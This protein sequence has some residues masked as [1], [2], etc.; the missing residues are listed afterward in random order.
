M[1]IINNTYRFICVHVPK[2]GG[3]SVTSA[4]SA[5]TNYCDQEIGATVFGEKIQS[6]YRDRFGLAKHSTAT[7]IRNLVGAVT[8]SRYFTFGFV[9]NPFTRALSTFHFLRKWE[10]PNNDFFER[11]RAFASFD[12]YVLS[13]IW[14]QGH[15]PDQ[16]FRPQA[17]WL[18]SPQGNRP[19]T[20]YIGRLETIGEDLR[21]V[22]EIVDAP[23]Q[24]IADVVVPHTNR[25]VAAGDPADVTADAR[26]IA[27]I[28]ERYR[29]DFEMFGYPQAVPGSE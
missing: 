4:L 10:G 12:E 23:R 28:I 20:A 8:W 2:A 15:G 9:R 11:M 17:Y 21:R 5:L 6:A 29:V 16:I 25:S 24:A 26:V 14:D 7:E 19:L 27:K 18:R 1:T 3:T 22:L 13:D